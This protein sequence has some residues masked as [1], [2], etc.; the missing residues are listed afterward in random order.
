MHLHLQAEEH[1]TMSITEHA[2]EGAVA[3]FN[4]TFLPQL[5]L[6]L[7]ETWNADNLPVCNL[8]GGKFPPCVGTLFATKSGA[9]QGF[10]SGCDAFAWLNK[11][12]TAYHELLTSS[13]DFV[14]RTK[15]GSRI[16]TSIP[17][18]DYEFPYTFHV[19]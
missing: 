6:D 3:V 5:A 10:F 17:I 18:V 2:W 13:I 16:G 11:T 9:Y 1:P 14:A 4:L 7:T 8:H 19:S 12:S 15:D